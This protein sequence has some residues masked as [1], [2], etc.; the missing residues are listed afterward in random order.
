M[1]SPG[2]AVPASAAST[3]PVASSPAA[4]G[5]ADPRLSLAG[6]SRLSERA[7]EEYHYVGRD[8]RNI[9]V[10][11]AVMAAILLAGYLVVSITGFARG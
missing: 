9:G 3:R 2:A 10:L 7:R 8:L 1:A 11:I 6:P 4:R 5:R